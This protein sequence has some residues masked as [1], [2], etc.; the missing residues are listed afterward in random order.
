MEDMGAGICSSYR[1]GGG[2]SDF[3]HPICEVAA[4]LA[5]VDGTRVL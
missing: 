4:G 1:R 2:G 3:V 5:V